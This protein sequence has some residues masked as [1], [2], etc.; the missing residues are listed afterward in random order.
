[1]G[2]VWVTVLTVLFGVGLQGVAVADE[3]DCIDNSSKAGC[4][5]PETRVDESIN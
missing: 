4:E 1:M 5:S 2:K 3:A